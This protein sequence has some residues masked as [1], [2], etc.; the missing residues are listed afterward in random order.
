MKYIN[1]TLKAIFV[2]IPV[3]SYTLSVFFFRLNRKC[4]LNDIDIE[5][6]RI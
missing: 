5:Y 2:Y 1:K 4:F 6:F 3:T